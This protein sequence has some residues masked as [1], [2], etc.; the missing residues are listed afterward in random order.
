MTTIGTSIVASTMTNSVTQQG[1]TP[2]PLTTSNIRNDLF[3][4][5]N[6]FE[7]LV[8]TKFSVSVDK[9]Q[10]LW[11]LNPVVPVSTLVPK[12]KALD[13]NGPKCVYVYQRGK[14]PGSTCG[15][16]VHESS[17]SG[18]YCKKHLKYDAVP[19]RDVTTKAGVLSA[20]KELAN[21]VVKPRPA[22]QLHISSNMY[23]NYEHKPTG[24][25]FNKEKKVYGRQVGDKVLELNSADLANCTRHGFAYL[26]ESVAKPEANKPTSSEVEIPDDTEI[27]EEEEE[28]EEVEVEEEELEEIEDPE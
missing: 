21:D 25:V 5:I 15:D 13:P 12:K 10:G 26:L 8:S 27:V 22:Q 3:M 23:G 14:N 28:V 1:T 16:P 4:S 19:P 7:T 9:L 11:A 6:K 2:F 24:L 20:A 17:T 18:S